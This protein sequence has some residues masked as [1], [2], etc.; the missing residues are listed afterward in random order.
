MSNAKN[1]HE[2]W[3][4]KKPSLEHIILFLCDVYVHVPK[5]NMI[6]MDNKV[7]KCIFIAFKDGMKGYNIWNP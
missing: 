1:T 5:E 3:I 2:V 4:G 6:K 7:E